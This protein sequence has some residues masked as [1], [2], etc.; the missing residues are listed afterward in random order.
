MYY[1]SILGLLFYVTPCLIPI[2]I[3]VGIIFVVYR[4]KKGKDSGSSINKF[5]LVHFYDLI[6]SQLT[7]ALSVLLFLY[8]LFSLTKSLNVDLEAPYVAL[9]GLIIGFILSY[10]LKQQLLLFLCVIGTYLWWI[11][12]SMSELLN[13]LTHSE[14]V[15]DR[16]YGYSSNDFRSIIIIVGTLLISLLFFVIAK[17]HSQKSGYPFFDKVYYFLSLIPG[18]VFIFLLS[19]EDVLVEVV[20]YLTAGN[21]LQIPPVLIIV[22]VLISILIILFTFYAYYEK[23][24]TYKNVVSVTLALFGI[25]LI[26]FIPKLEL[27]EVSSSD[28]PNIYDILNFLGYILLIFFN[29]LVFGE[30]LLLILYGYLKKS[31]AF[32]SLGTL[33]LFFLCIEKYVEWFSFTEKGLFFTGAGILMLVLGFL[34]ERARRSI[35]N[36]LK[37]NQNSTPIDGK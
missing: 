25:A 15:D 6:I 1:Y 5:N 21:P 8:L 14:L 9:P 13:L 33:L 10:Y 22:I 31:I 28:Y 37:T 18:S 24:V 27:E 20:P 12:L 4:V 17:I 11:W 26:L 30:F 32:I 23:L 7:I 34:L 2:L 19:I 3:I 36:N 29:I 35:I 16:L